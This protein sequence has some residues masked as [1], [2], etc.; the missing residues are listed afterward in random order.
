MGALHLCRGE[1]AAALTHFQEALQIARR[2]GDKISTAKWLHNLALTYK[3]MGNPVLAKSCEL[4]KESL[5]KQVA[6]ARAAAQ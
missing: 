6:A 3:H 1:Y 2:L 5:D 4:E